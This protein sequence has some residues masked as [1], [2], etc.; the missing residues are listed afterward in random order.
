MD[1]TWL[2][3]NVIKFSHIIHL[4]KGI[5]KK[6]TGDLKNLEN[7]EPNFLLE[8]LRELQKELSTKNITLI[9][10]QNC[11]S[12]GIPRWIE[13]LLVTDLYYQNEWTSEERIV[14][15]R[16]KKS[17]RRNKNSYILRSIFISP[18]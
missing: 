2:Q 8:S 3:K 10:D 16:L 18:R 9:I 4:T 1:F 11:A 14:S 5:S 15:E 13:K 7:L 17:F 6:P 12:E